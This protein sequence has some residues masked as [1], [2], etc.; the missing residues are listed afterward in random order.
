MRRVCDVVVPYRMLQRFPPAYAALK[1]SPIFTIRNFLIWVI[2]SFL[3]ALVLFFFAYGVFHLE[4]LSGDGQVYDMWG[5]GEMLFAGIIVVL[6]L[7][8]LCETSHWTWFSVSFSALGIMG[9]ILVCGVYSELDVYV[10]SLPFLPAPCESLSWRVV[11]VFDVRYAPHMYKIFEQIYGLRVMW[12]YVF[13][14]TVT[15][16]LFDVTRL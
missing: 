9:L 13:L 10:P 5:F 7:K 16:L 8:F 4:V 1:A 11:W 12:L 15:S 6:N 2:S 3:H 14:V